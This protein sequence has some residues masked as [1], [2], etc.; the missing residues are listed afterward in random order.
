MDEL[1]T[2]VREPERMDRVDVAFHERIMLVSGNQLARAIVKTVHLEARRSIR[3]SGSVSVADRQRTNRQHRA[4]LGAIVAGDAEL[5]A[6][7]MAD[8]INDAWR[9]RRPRSPRPP[10]HR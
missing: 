1:D 4:V 8:H 6:S 9:R 3:Y 5:A 10:A 7:L 2:C